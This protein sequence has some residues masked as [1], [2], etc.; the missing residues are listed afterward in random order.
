MM[1]H[2]IFLPGDSATSGS[3]RVIPRMQK[4]KSPQETASATRNK[5][6]KNL[7]FFPGFPAFLRVKG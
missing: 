1:R 6:L 7:L 4:Q 2:C 5:K 3:L